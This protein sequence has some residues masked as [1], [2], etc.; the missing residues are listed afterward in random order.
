MGRTFS[1]KTIDL[2]RKNMT[3]RTFSDE[4]RSK[5][6]VSYGGVKVYVCSDPA[7]ATKVATARGEDFSKKEEFPN[8]VAAANYLNISIRTLDRRCKDGK[9]LFPRAGDEHCRRAGVKF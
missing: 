2:I 6:S 3:G 9:P 7:R 8:K 4:I 1:D 5:I